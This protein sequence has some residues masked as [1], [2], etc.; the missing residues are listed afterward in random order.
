M[1]YNNKRC[2]VAVNCTWQK[3]I[4]T[5]QL[6]NK[7]HDA[8]YALSKARV[9]RRNI[10]RI[11]I[12]FSWLFFSIVIAPA[13]WANSEVDKLLDLLVEK[14]TITSEEAAVF[15]ADQAVGRQEEKEQQ[16]EFVLIAGKLLKLSGYTNVRYRD[17]ENGN[18]T[19]DVRRVR[20]NIQGDI[21]E[22]FDYRTQVEFGGGK[23][24]LIDGIL[25]YKVNPY[26][27]LSL[28]QFLIPFSQENIVSNTKLETINRSQVVEALTARGTDV[29]GNQN[30]RDIGLQGAGTFGLLD[31]AVALFNGAGINTTDTNKTKDIIGRLVFH[32]AK[33][34]SIGGSYYTGKY[35]LAS[36]PTKKDDRKRAGAEIA[37]S[38]EVYS[39]KGEYIQGKDASIKKNGWY[40]QATYFLIPKKLQGVFKFDTFDP[41]KDIQTNESGVYTL[42]G[43]WFFNK[44]TYA[45]INYEAKNEAGREVNNN[46]LSGQFTLQF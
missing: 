9:K 13:L 18:D 25:G 20:L 16:K 29:I 42:G 1:G 15:R 2:T 35:T 27:K 28:G 19:F 44:W 22:R 12:V 40:A 31:Y 36:A 3:I 17:I 14:G 8:E 5:S 37:Y 33:D 26:L 39:L 7:K 38:K 43:N 45:Q 23:V 34:W 6:E 46:V 41:N 30:G 21:T 11:F 4:K 10:V 32:P 24:A